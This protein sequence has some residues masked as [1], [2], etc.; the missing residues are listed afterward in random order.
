VGAHEGPA[1]ARSSVCGFTSAVFGHC[2]QVRGPVSGGP[3]APGSG[4]SFGLIHLCARPFTGDR[5]LPLRTG[6]GR[7]RTVV[8]AGAQY[9]K[10][11]E[12]AT[13]P[14]VQIPPPPPLT[15]KNTDPGRRRPGASGSPGLIW[16]AQ[17]GTQNGPITGLSRRCRAWSRPSRTTLNTS[18]HALEACALRSGLAGTVRDWP[19][20]RQPTDRIT[21]SDREVLENARRAA[22]LRGCLLG[23]GHGEGHPDWMICV[24]Q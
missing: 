19:D 15:C 17:L 12:G 5:G 23:S 3:A 22:Q 13:P 21:L 4:L 7:W 10:A 2:R 11:C 6:Q 16:W 9:S 14:W 1:A 24:C 20:P 8:N 18:M